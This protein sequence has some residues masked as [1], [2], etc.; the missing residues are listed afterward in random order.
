ML[1]IGMYQCLEIIQKNLNNQVNAKRKL[2]AI[3]LYSNGHTQQPVNLPNNPVL[4]NNSTQQQ[5]QD[6]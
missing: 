4:N 3:D 2:S 6:W 5:L 1:I